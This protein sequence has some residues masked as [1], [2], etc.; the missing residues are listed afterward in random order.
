MLERLE[1]ATEEW[2]TLLSSFPVAFLNQL[3][4]LVITTLTTPTP[5]VALAATQIEADP[6]YKT[7]SLLQQRVSTTEHWLP[8][9]TVDDVAAFI[10]A[11]ASADLPK[12]LH[13]WGGGQPVIIE[14]VWTTWIR[15]EVVQQDAT[16][17]WM[18]A[19]PN[20]IA[21]GQHDFFHDLLKARLGAEHDDWEFLNSLLGYAAIEG[22]TCTAE[23]ISEAVSVRLDDVLEL[24]DAYTL[25]TDST[26]GVLTKLDER[27]VSGDEVV[28][29]YRFTSLAAWRVWARYTDDANVSERQR[30]I[31]DALE[32][33]Y[34]GADDAVAERLITLFE[35]T[36]QPKRAQPYRVRRQYAPNNVLALLWQLYLR[37]SVAET[38]YEWQGVFNLHLEIA[39]F[40][41]DTAQ[42][43]KAEQQARAAL[44]LP[45][46]IPKT[47]QARAWSYLAT[48]LQYQGDYSAAR[49]MYERALA[50]DEKVYG[51]NHPEVAT[52]LNN[53]ALLLYDLQDFAH[54]Q[55][56][57]Q[58]ALAILE[59]TL[60]PNHPNIQTVRRGLAA[61][62]AKLREQKRRNVP[63]V[64]AKQRQG[65]GDIAAKLG[66]FKK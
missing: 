56:L 55:R 21:D 36:D 11:T 20:D 38:P 53:L 43:A 19:K 12:R 39:S 49:P 2:R 62:A 7:L 15:D 60:P 35:A 31:A 25:A 41:I 61:I 66:K 27:I 50:I 32:V 4:L 64:E 45:Y 58:R 37:R 42:Y 34:H 9:V 13:E 26:P 18:S 59:Q 6:T 24:F 57:M 51:A 52:N 65:L 14:D 40:Y 8:A 22:V 47:E 28:T 1:Y 44:E 10:G 5:F 63:N 30:T 54:A 3:P 33:V 17:R 48:S 23:V 46:A 16:G 29:R